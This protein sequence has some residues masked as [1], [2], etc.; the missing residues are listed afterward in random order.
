MDGVRWLPTP[1]I[2]RAIRSRKPSGKKTSGNAGYPADTGDGSEPSR[3][4][5]VSRR[6][7]LRTHGTTSAML[8]AGT[9]AARD[10][11]WLRAP[12]CLCVWRGEP[13]AG[14]VGLATVPRDEYN[15]NGRVPDPSQPGSPDRSHRDG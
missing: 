5:D 4:F 7:P 8:G 15:Q 13:V 1:A 9:P 10:Q 2:P 12:V 3:A 14:P 6:S 11:Q